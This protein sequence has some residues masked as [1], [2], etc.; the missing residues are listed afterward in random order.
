MKD[1]NEILSLIEDIQELPVSEESI[2]AYIE[3]T[4]NETELKSV[5]NIIVNDD[6]LNQL[7]DSVNDISN[8]MDNMQN[9]PDSK[10]DW[11]IYSGD[12]GFWEFGILS[13]IKNESINIKSEN[14]SSKKNYGYEPNNELD[15]F[16]P[17]IWQGNQPT[18]AIRSQEIILRDYGIYHTQ[19]ELVEF[20]TQQGWFNPDPVYGGTDKNAIGNILDACGIPT[21]R[22]EDATIHD[23][24]SELRAG[25]RVIVSVDANELWV[26]NE[27]NLFKKLYGQVVNKANDKVQDFLGLEG[28]NHALVVAGVNVNPKDPSDIK[29][30]LIDSGTG[31]VC[32]EYD[33]KD[34]YNAW[35]D[36]HCQMI[37]TDI[38]APFQYNYHTHQIEP[39]NIATTYSP[40]MA[41]M[42]EGLT[43]QFHI[44]E[45]FFKE[46]KEYSPE[47]NEKIKVGMESIDI[48]ESSISSSDSDMEDSRID[49]T[50][51]TGYESN[52]QED[53]LPDNTVG[54]DFP[55]SGSSSNSTDDNNAELP[56]EDYSISSSESEEDESEEM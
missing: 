50:V 24:I 10:I 4:L 5:E 53:Q 17:N 48:H 29:V 55:E 56:E 47:Y 7:L 12:M 19:E 46:F 11:D 2:G 16:D 39:S 54:E 38:P 22:T 18:C 3:G 49:D 36:G 6:R 21:T 1:L 28:A 9:S 43:N 35:V 40:S 13:I 26:K 51:Q 41:Q 32:I 42:P 37:S 34:F 15:K 8:D 27:P 52:D 23:I 45:E 30:T 44:S 20:A 33:F 25:H 14:M 31:E